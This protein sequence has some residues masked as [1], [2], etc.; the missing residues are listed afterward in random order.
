MFDNA[1]EQQNKPHDKPFKYCQIPIGV[2]KEEPFVYLRDLITMLRPNVSNWN[3]WIDS[4]QNIQPHV[5]KSDRSV[6]ASYLVS[7]LFERVIELKDE[8]TGG[9]FKDIVIASAISDVIDLAAKYDKIATQDALQ[10]FFY[11]PAAIADLMVG[12]ALRQP[13][14]RSEYINLA[15]N[16]VHYYGM[17]YII[18]N[19]SPDAEY[20]IFEI[21]S[22]RVLGVREKGKS[23]TGI[24]DV[25]P[26][27]SH[28]EF[29]TGNKSRVIKVCDSKGIFDQTD[30]NP[31]QIAEEK[32]TAFLDNYESFFNSDGEF[33]RRCELENINLNSLS[34][35]SKFE[36][37]N[38]IENSDENTKNRIFRTLRT[39]GLHVDG[40]IIDIFQPA[41]GNVQYAKELASFAC[42]AMEDQGSAIV[43]NYEYFNFIKNVFQTYLTVNS[44]H[45]NLAAELLTNTQEPTKILRLASIIRDQMNASMR[46]LTSL[47]ADGQKLTADELK[48]VDMA[49][50]GYARSLLILA[51]IQAGQKPFQ[52]EI[53]FDIYNWLLT[54]HADHPNLNAMVNAVMEYLSIRAIANQ[55]DIKQE[56]I[57]R[58]ME[59]LYGQ[60]KTVEIFDESSA[61]AVVTA[62]TRKERER[63]ARLIIE[64]RRQGWLDKDVKVKDVGSYDGERVLRPTIEA[65]ENATAKLEQAEQVQFTDIQGIDAYPPN[66]SWS[67]LKLIQANLS[68]PNDITRLRAIA[69]GSADLLTE[70]W[71]AVQDD[72]RQLK[73]E[74][75]FRAYSML[76][77]P[78]R[79]KTVRGIQ[80]LDLSYDDVCK[81][82]NNDQ[83]S[84]K[85]GEY[86]GG[87]YC[88][89]TALPLPILDPMAG[90][91]KS[92]YFRMRLLHTMH[93]EMIP[94]V[95]PI[96]PDFNETAHLPPDAVD[97]YIYYINQLINFGKRAGMVPI[98]SIFY[99]AAALKAEIDKI[100]HDT[101]YIRKR[102]EETA[103]PLEYPFWITQ[104]GYLRVFIPMVKLADPEESPSIVMNVVN[105]SFTPIKIE[106]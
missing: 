102:T 38:A 71:S 27:Y 5:E 35:K 59:A 91:A 105:S 6:F 16:V 51:D 46:N 19:L 3:D 12:S 68:R 11:E 92:H 81:L 67:R 26:Y 78:P 73:H 100:S 98:N 47:T 43:R 24:L 104:N 13:I 61:V 62:D 86:I 103:D 8:I 29:N 94:N 64:L 69:A 82:K 49:F 90:N 53:E 85:P 79:V 74:T 44:L 50:N 33:A 57:D 77:R 58:V 54:E 25:H 96:L 106:A 66:C 21:E 70:F 31:A 72:P 41:D 87:I 40:N 55:Y 63:W 23:A 65:V 7:G 1:T 2:V 10:S 95:K 84:G 101:A 34:A 89:D 75:Y 22:A 83:K 42:S 30:N 20:E 15:G 17:D 97:A 45:S 37:Y 80:L 32:I 99:D 76:V 14:M 36:I 39:Y 52:E 93:P 9:P 88:I 60:N 56:D 18:E 4:V 48:L 28:S